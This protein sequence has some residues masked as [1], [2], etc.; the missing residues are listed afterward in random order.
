MTLNE[1]RRAASVTDA[2]AQ[3]W[4]DPLQG[5]MKRYDINTPKRQ[6]AFIAQMAHESLGFTCVSE[7]LYYKD[8][9]RIAQIF[10]T[11]FD[12]NHNG[13]VDPAEVEFAKGY[14]RN[15]VKLANRAYAN[16]NG[17][18]DEASGDGYRYRGRGPLQNTGKGN[19]QKTGDAIGVDL[20]ADPDKLADPKVGALAAAEYWH[21]TGCNELADKDD[22]SGITVAI[23]GKAMQGQADRLAR[24]KQ[25]KS[26]LLAA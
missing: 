10:K 2:I 4:F 8:P 19:Y 25:A 1:F 23:N 3:Q 22:F 5:A 26:V 6:A 18:G 9:V 17:N 20:V 7:S 21:R 13:K 16:R 12:L 14:V 15:S 24:W 11:G